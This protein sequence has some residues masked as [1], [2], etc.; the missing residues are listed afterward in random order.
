MAGGGK[1]KLA[2]G[3]AIEEPGLQDTVLH[4]GELA[5]AD[6]LAVERPRAQAAPAQRIID[7]ADARREQA[8]AE[9]VPEKAGLA[10]NRAAVDGASQMPDDAA[11]NARIEHDRNP[12]GRNLARV[13]ALDRALAGTFA[14]RFGG[15]EIG[16][17]QDRREIVVAFHRGA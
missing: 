16:A 17:V 9:L 7:N 10:R 2:G 15:L 8:L 12:L 11:G 3:R 6:A 1:T 5:A 14:D 13:G 4:H